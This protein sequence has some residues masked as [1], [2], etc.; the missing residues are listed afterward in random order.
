[1]KPY[2][3]AHDL[4][5]TG[6]K[7]T[8]FDVEGRLIAAQ[9]ASYETSYAEGNRAEQDP[10][11][12][13]EAVCRTSRAILA[14]VPGDEIA[15]VCLSGQMM[16]CLCV[17]RR[18]RPLR[19]SIIYSDQR[20]VEQ[21]EGLLSRIG[22]DELYR[23]CG[24]RASASYSIEKLMWVRDDE[25]E[26]YRAT[27]KML[28]AKDYINFRLTGRYLTDYN[29]ASGTNCFDIATKGWSERIL[30][31]AE[32]EPRM[33]PEARESTSVAGG[34]TKEAA[35]ETG[36]AVGTPVVIGAGDG[37][38]ATVGVGCVAEGVTYNYLGSTAWISTASSA[39]L[40]DDAMRT[41]T[42]VHPVPGLYQ[43]C[44][45]VQTAGSSV[46]W[47]A[48][49]F[50]LPSGSGFSESSAFSEA[51]AYERIDEEAAGSP[52]GSNG[53]V[54]LPYLLG[55]R[56]PRWNPDAKGAW[57]G[58]KL[59]NSRA[60]L[61]RAV[62]EGVAFNLEIVLSVMRRKVPAEE[63]VLIGGGA[64]SAV[65]RQILADVYGVSLRIP[66]H[67]EEATSMGAA[68]IGGVGVGSF[69]FEEGA[70]RFVRIVESVHPH[71]EAVRFYAERKGLFEE[72]YA[73]LE[74]TMT[75]L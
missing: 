8:L 70:R 54:F 21:T 10:A 34:I 2:L 14:S 58:L 69:D 53:V 62:L 36:L 12:W 61:A 64:Q 16:G 42:W 15:A 67:L 52:P 59:S 29:D 27:E 75:R 41:F 1:M 45:T 3:L 24:H 50:F 6:D 33:M 17:D 73:R 48:R 56:S 37:G 13:W 39:P 4:G 32:I 5:T 38:C 35:A 49:Q 55:E 47:L 74:E 26:V 57:I 23:I 9:S 22:G 71:K 28:N 51:A 18:G 46:G 31:L 11:D 44:G 68:L 40:I 20:A 60:D 72:C 63:L 7:A 65:W 66:E 19:N 30:E 43:P 25:P